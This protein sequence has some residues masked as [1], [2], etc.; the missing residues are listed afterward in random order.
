V[1][2]F[3]D[4][5]SPF[6]HLIFPDWAASVHRQGERLS[7]L[8]K[9]EWSAR[10]KVLD[11]SC[12][13]GTQAI[14]LSLQ[15]YLVTASDLSSNQI[16][17]AKREAI[18]FGVNLNLSVCD[19]RQAHSHHG[20]G[21][22]IVLSADNSIPHLL[23]DSDILLALKQMLACLS[24]GGGCVITVRDY[25]KEER[26]QN[27]VKPYGVRVENGK[28]FIL[29]QVWDFEGDYYDLSFFI[30]EESLSTHDT[31]THLMRSRYYAMT[32]QK[33][34]ELMCEAGFQKVRRIDDAFYQPVLVGTRAE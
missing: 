29:F 28:R 14:G 2:H 20:S 21:F 22:D 31:K 33:I 16:E 3:Y 25:A 12:G 10:K 9:S 18:Q 8:I 34:E 11:I 1:S 19:M 7:T 30:V 6:Y 23:T 27:L 5:L 4:Q 24:V 32:I 13:I 15:G 17:R 26:G